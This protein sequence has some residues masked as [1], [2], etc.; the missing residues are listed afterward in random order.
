MFSV[1]DHGTLSL[2]G[3]EAKVYRQVLKK[4]G[5]DYARKEDIS[6]WTIERALQ[7]AI[8]TALDP[9]EQQVGTTLNDRIEAALRNLR[10]DLSR[11]ATRHSCYT[12]VGGLDDRELPRS[13]GSTRFVIFNES[14]LRKLRFDLRKHT[15]QKKSKTTIIN[16]IRNS[17]LWNHVCALVEVAAKDPKA[18][19]ALAQRDARITIDVLNFFADV[20]PYEHGWVYL[21]GEA[22]TLNVTSVIRGSDKSFW[23]PGRVEGPLGP[24][25][26]RRLRAEE[27]LGTQVSKLH[28]LL[29]S[30]ERSRIEELFVAAVRWA[31]RAAVE[32]KTEQSFLLYMI[33]LESIVL[34]VH[35][36]TT[37]YRL[38]LR[39]AH[40]LARRPEHRTRIMEELQKLSLARNAIVHKGSFKVTD[41]QLGLMRLYTH[42]VILR[43]LSDRSVAR[44][45]SPE[46][47]N[48]WFESQVLR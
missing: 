43:L 24:F 48:N 9:R 11:S 32:Q 40:L 17:E 30:K 23:I 1:R 7:A 16:D 41:D 3:T 8:L 5:E 45:K 39:I 37:N 35:L 29:R 2:Y 27:W 6:A 44:C 19:E 14:Q 31:G 21:R 25:S 38:R 20:M 36:G 42:L 46:A 4:L 18:A 10:N 28:R 15:K 47:L 13:F 12:P 26:I 22:I 33:A 34:P